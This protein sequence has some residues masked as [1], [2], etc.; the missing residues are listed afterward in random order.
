[1]RLDPR[2]LRQFL[3]VCRE[4]TISG[5]AKAEHVSQPSISMAMNQLERVLEVKLF[6]RSSKGMIFFCR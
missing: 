6:Q 4:G 3:A 2:M 5:A 1:M